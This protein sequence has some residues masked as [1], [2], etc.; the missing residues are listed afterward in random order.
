MDETGST[1]G[2]YGKR[3]LWQWILLYIII[4]GLIYG[5]VYYFFLAK[6]G[7]YSENETNEYKSTQQNKP[8]TVTSTSQPTTA[9]SPAMTQQEITIEGNEFAFTPSTLTLKNGQTVKITFKNMG[10][11]PHNWAIAALNVTTKTIQPAE[12][13]TIEF[14]PNKTGTFTYTCTVDSHAEKGMKGTLTIQ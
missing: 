13:D 9:T 2:N 10:K 12:Q 6:K 3:P 5:G 1:Q 11:Y 7:G 8:N 4:G 14:T